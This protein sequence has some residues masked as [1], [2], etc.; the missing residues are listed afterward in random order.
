MAA[1]KA[2]PTEK[3]PNPIM[4]KDEFIEMEPLTPKG[5]EA[6][7]FAVARQPGTNCSLPCKNPMN[8]PHCKVLYLSENP[9]IYPFGKPTA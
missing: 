7:S 5:E 4:G 8:S 6:F 2:I 3:R 1:L 9:D